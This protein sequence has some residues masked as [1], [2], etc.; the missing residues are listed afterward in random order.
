MEDS[1]L[2]KIFKIPDLL[3]LALSL[4]VWV[5]FFFLSWYA[6]GLV[7][8]LFQNKNKKIYKIQMQC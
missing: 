7:P 1:V 5:G 4:V 8:A 2:M 3:W 6:S